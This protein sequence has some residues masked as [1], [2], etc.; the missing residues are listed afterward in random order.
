MNVKH[1]FRQCLPLGQKITIARH[2]MGGLVIL[3]LEWGTDYGTPEQTLKIGR[4][5]ALR[6]IL[7]ISSSRLICY[8]GS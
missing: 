6:V 8:W 7:S 3:H 4:W 5:R 1:E 2:L